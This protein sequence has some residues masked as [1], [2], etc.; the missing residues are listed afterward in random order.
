MFTWDDVMHMRVVVS[1]AQIG[2]ASGTP[3]VGV[4]QRL[5]AHTM[6][7]SCFLIQVFGMSHA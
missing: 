7:P 1:I 6:K 4:V 5:L 3:I 2:I